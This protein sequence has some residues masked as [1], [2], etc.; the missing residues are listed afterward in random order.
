MLRHN[1]LCRASKLKQA[2][3]N[4]KPRYTMPHSSALE[5]EQEDIS[6][7]D[8]M[9]LLTSKHQQTKCHMNIISFKDYNSAQAS[10]TL[11]RSRN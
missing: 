10:F 7:K 5:C 11:Y 2:L 8:I 6:D 3:K 1:K 4:I 9:S